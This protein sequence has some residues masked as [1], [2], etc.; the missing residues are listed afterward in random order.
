MCA[1]YAAQEGCVVKGRFSEESLGDSVIPRVIAAISVPTPRRL[2]VV[3]RY[4]VILFLFR[5][6]IETDRR[7]SR[8]A[9]GAEKIFGRK[10][11]SVAS[12][13]TLHHR[14]RVPSLRVAVVREI[15]S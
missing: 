9:R 1:G 13:S 6:A 12:Q 11:L 8:L 14:S 4:H 10:V 15:P 3:V 5:A 2:R 7:G